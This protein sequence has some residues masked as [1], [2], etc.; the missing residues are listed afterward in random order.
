MA[1]C[2][3]VMKKVYDLELSQT[4]AE[5]LRSYLSLSLDST[6]INPQYEDMTLKEQRNIIQ[7]I[8]R[9]LPEAV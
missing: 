8:S 9:T 4:E 6:T 3:V 1:K 5:L 2:H 7:Q